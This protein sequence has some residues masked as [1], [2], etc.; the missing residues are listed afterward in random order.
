[1]CRVPIH[2]MVE[3]LGNL[4]KNATEAA[5]QRE[6]K[7]IHV[8]MLED[9]EKIQIEIS[10]ESEIIDEKRIKDF[11]KKKYSEKG[12]NRGYGLYNVRIICEEYGAAIIC[13]NDKGEKKVSDDTQ[14]VVSTSSSDI[15]I[16]LMISI[17]Y[18]IVCAFCT[19][20]QKIL[21]KQN[22][23]GEVQN[24]Y[25]GMYNTLPALLMVI[26]EGHAG[27]NNKWYVLYGLSNGFLLAG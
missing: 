10:N 12:N 16:G 13:K 26:I 6:K 7:K 20:G 3:L 15:F 23:S 9:S 2:K 25:L 18:L 11:F 19:F 1:M 27:L 17:V 4:L 21:C 24:Y 14:T 22:M 8:M 5:K